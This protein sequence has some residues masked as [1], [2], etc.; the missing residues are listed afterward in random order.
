MPILIFPKLLKL[1]MKYVI[2]KT[3]HHAVLLMKKKYLLKN[4]IGTKE[5][6]L[7]SSLDSTDEYSHK[8]KVSDAIYGDSKFLYYFVSFYGKTLATI[9][10]TPGLL[11]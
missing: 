5:Q 6:R 1:S 3:S 4:N 2:H 10:L 7:E 9:C 11:C 8:K